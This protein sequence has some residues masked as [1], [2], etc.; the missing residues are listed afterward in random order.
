MDEQV[1]IDTRCRL[2]ANWRGLSF[3]RDAE[4]GFA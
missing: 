1:F 4:D 2:R 3:I